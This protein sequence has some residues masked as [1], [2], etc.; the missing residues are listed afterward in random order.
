MA[1]MQ[2]EGHLASFIGTAHLKLH[3]AAGRSSGFWLPGLR[4]HG[5][6]SVVH[7]RPTK[8]R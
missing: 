8:Q 3:L 5:G 7:Q 1:C 6:L 2:A 4:A